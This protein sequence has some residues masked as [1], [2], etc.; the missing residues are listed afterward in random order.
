MKVLFGLHDKSVT[1]IYAAIFLMHLGGSIGPIISD[2]R[3]YLGV[4]YAIFGLALSMYGFGRMMTDVPFGYIADRL[5]SKRL[6]I[7]GAFVI[8]AGSALSAWSTT[9]PQFSIGRILSGIGTAISATVALTTLSRISSQETRG[10]VLNM[11]FICLRTAGVLSPAVTGYLASV[12]N[13]RAPFFFHAATAFLALP[14]LSALYPSKRP[15]EK[16]AKVEENGDELAYSNLRSRRLGLR[17]IIP[18][19]IVYSCAFLL[20]FNRTGH[21]D[22]LLPI[23]ARET[24]GLDPATLGLIL[25]AVAILRLV[26]GIPSGWLADKYGSKLVLIIG[27]LLYGVG[28][29]LFMFVK[30]LIMFI[31][32]YVILTVGT[33]NSAML[34]VILT[35]TTPPSKRGRYIGLYR[36]SGDIGAFLGPLILSFLLDYFGFYNATLFVLGLSLLAVMLSA[37][38]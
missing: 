12:F 30:N 36:F 28:V 8:V 18:V 29:F 37:K 35:D 33:L 32:A 2:I 5:S 24:L 19:L 38:L 16:I 15:V 31:A 34:S 20:F 14:L 3:T 13:W 9:F 27:Y 26:S 11:Y 25:S 6:L 1:A 22:T 17:L 23:F 21:R 10:R 4:S 7:F